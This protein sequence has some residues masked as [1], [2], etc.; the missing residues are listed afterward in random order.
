MAALGVNF[1]QYQTANAIG[2][3]GEGAAKG[4]DA[5]CFAGI[6]AGLGAGFGISQVVAQNMYSNKIRTYSPSEESM[7]HQLDSNK[8]R[9]VQNAGYVS[10]SQNNILS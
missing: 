3:I 9:P 5:A 4:G 2:G 10:A 6:G 8:Q 1:L 7:Q